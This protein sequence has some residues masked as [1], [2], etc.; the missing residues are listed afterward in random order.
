[1]DAAVGLVQ[2]YLRINGFFTVTEY[3][4]VT[5]A[6]GAGRTLTDLDV[7][8]VRFPGAGRWVPGDDAMLPTD[9]LLEPHDKHLSMIIGEVKE[10]QS[11]F[12]PAVSRQ[13]VVETVIRRFGCCSGDPTATARAVVENGFSDT[14][15]ASGMHCRIRWIVFGGTA[16]EASSLSRGSVEARCRVPHR[17]HQPPSK[18]VSQDS[19]EGRDT[20]R[21]GL[22]AEARAARRTLTG[23][24]HFLLPHLV[25]N[26]F[27]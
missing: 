21:D 15:V 18:C 1:M 13:D 8:A 12:N 23:R 14:A 5:R 10:G 11:R 27:A 16:P 20:G 9:P 24:Q 17:P 6:H 25:R 7:L 3:P 22:A 2:A 26:N 4:I 19:V